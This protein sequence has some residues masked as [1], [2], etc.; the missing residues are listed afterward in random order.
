MISRM[1]SIQM[2]L[3]CEL[4]ESA[5]RDLFPE[6]TS[7]CVEAEA[8][9]GRTT[10]PARGAGAPGARSGHNRSDPDTNELFDSEFARASRRY[11]TGGNARPS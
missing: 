8:D 2:W 4:T 1:N 10:S 7:V 6:R 9:N 3:Q 11:S 5:I